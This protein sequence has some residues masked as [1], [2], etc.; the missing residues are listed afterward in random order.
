ML[1]ISTPVSLGGLQCAVVA[2]L[3]SG[4]KTTKT[5]VRKGD[6]G[7]CLEVG[8]KKVADATAICRFLAHGDKKLA[9]TAQAGAAGQVDELVDLS[10]AVE[11]HVTNQQTPTELLQWV[12]N[13]RYG[14]WGASPCPLS[15]QVESCMASTPLCLRSCPAARSE[16]SVGC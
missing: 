11:A 8:S 13:R 10:Q 5:T 7:V 1:S 6:G 4:N 3:C 9:A 12:Q 16:W 14:N 15:A 2:D